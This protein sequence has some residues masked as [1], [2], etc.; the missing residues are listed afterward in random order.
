M[1]ILSIE[2]TG[3]V[4]SVSVLDTNQG[5]ILGAINLNFGLTHS[6]TLLII[7]NQL[8]ETL[9]IEPKQIN[10]VACSS[11]PGSFTGI[12][13]GAATAK[14]FAHGL[15]IQIINIPTLDAMAL[16]IFAPDSIILPLL[17]ARR[18]QIYGAIYEYVTN[19]TTKAADL[20]RISEYENCEIEKII[21]KSIIIAQSQNKK[22]ILLGDGVEANKKAIKDSFSSYQNYFLAPINLNLQSAS[23]VAMLAQKILSDSNSNQDSNSKTPGTK[24]KDFLPFYLRKHES[25]QD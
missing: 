11:G 17:D 16:N 13:I 3:K 12:K 22:I 4:A 18:G 21:N 8:L 24:Y 6:Q 9:N 5:K 23:S 25:E 2:A 20:K 1:N 14:A 15:D 7:I 10:Y 19:N